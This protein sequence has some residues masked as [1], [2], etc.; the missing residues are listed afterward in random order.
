MTAADRQ[1]DSA[2]AQYRAAITEFDAASSVIDAR[3]LEGGRPT[4]DELS[5]EELARA[6]LLVARRYLV[7]LPWVA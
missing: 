3:I 6:K 5:T 4:G 1:Y 7:A 2:A